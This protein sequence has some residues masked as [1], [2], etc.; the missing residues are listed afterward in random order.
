VLHAGKP[1]ARRPRTAGAAGRWPGTGK[2][3]RQLLGYAHNHAEHRAGEE[4]REARGGGERGRE[5]AHHSDERSGELGRRQRRGR[6]A[7]RL[8]VLCGMGKERGGRLVV[9]AREEA[10]ST[11]VGDHG[12]GFA[13]QARP[14]CR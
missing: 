7:A 6:E 5:E 10:T 13:I 1:R 12:S 14:R 9:L 4:E 8:R 3:R 2:P 11:R